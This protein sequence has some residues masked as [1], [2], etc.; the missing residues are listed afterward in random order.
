MTPLVFERKYEL[1]SLCAFFKL[2]HQYFTA[3]GDL[4]PFDDEWLKAVSLALDTMKNMQRPSL[5]T[6]PVYTFQRCAYVLDI[7]AV[8]L[9]NL[10]IISSTCVSSSVCRFTGVRITR[11]IQN[12]TTIAL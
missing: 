8:S 4:S 2:S 7:L 9:A 3:T 11:Y 6:E 12:N 5:G 10:A 1:D